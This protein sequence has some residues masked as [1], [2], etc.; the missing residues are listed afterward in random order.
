MDIIAHY[1]GARVAVC[2]AAERPELVR[3]LVLTGAAGI[4][5]PASAEKQKKKAAYQ[6]GKKVIAALGHLP[7]MK[8]A[9]DRLREKLKSESDRLEKF[10]IILETND[11]RRIMK[12]GYSILSDDAGHMISDAALLETGEE[13]LLTLYKGRAH[14]RI[15]SL[16]VSEDQL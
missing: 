3:R 12:N 11:P 13:Y 6:R 2:L 9:A 8:D 10:R 15:T 16:E 7:G 4:R 1:F 14:C 5:P